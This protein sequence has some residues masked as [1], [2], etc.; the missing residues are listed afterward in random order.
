[1]RIDEYP[2]NNPSLLENLIE[3]SRLVETVIFGIGGHDLKIEVYEEISPSKNYSYKL[4]ERKIIKQGSEDL[5][6]WVFETN[7]PFD[8][9]NSSNDALGTALRWIKDYYPKIK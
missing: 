1:M 3:F 5:E 9:A 7:F 8:S 2:Y 4:Y 6:T